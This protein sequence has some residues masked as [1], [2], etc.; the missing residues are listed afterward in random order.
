MGRPQGCPHHEA[1]APR[2]RLRTWISLTV[3]A[4]AVLW[5]IYS[6]IAVR[7]MNKASNVDFLIATDSEMKKVNWTSR[8][9]LIGTTKAPDSR[10]D[11]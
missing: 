5:V 7:M 3:L 9:A 2:R 4:A 10:R 11:S 8:R 1:V 6:F